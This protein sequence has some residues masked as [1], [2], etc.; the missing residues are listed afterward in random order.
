MNRNRN[1]WARLRVALMLVMYCP[2]VLI[3]QVVTGSISGR[4]TDTTGAVIAGAT[5]Q[6]Q[7]LEMGL[8]RTA[9]TDSAGRYVARNLPVGPYSV[10]AQQ[11]GFQKQIRNGITLAVGSEAVVNLELSVGTVQETVQVSGEAPSVETTQ[12]TLSSLINPEQMRELPLNGRSYDQLALLSP[13]VVS[14]P[15]GTRNQTQGAGLCL[16]SNGARADANVYLLDG[17]VVNDHSS[18]RR[19]SEPGNR[20]HSGVPHSDA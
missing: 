12:A 9:E 1:R 11:Q 5:I 17:T 15:D 3:A 13:G 7:N 14:Q 10:A 4:V 19:R 6:I 20:S 8:S 16:S 18:Q 2:A